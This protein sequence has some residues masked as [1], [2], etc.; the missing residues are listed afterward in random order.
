MS[1]GSGNRTT[2]WKAFREGMDRIA[3]NEKR[4]RKDEE[5]WH[6]SHRCEWCGEYWCACDELPKDMRPEG[7]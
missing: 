3:E 6:D 5:L 4:R 7:L 1:K 2:N